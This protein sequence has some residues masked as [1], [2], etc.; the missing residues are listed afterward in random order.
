MLR[1]IC[2]SSVIYHHVHS[3]TLLSW[4][5]EPFRALTWNKTVRHHPAIRDELLYH[6]YFLS[7]TTALFDL[8]LLGVVMG[9]ILNPWFFV[10]AAPFLVCKYRDGGDHLDVAG[11]VVR[12]AAGCVR[13]AIILGVLL[14]SSVR[15]R[16]L[17]I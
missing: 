16:S 6:R 10:L 17:V 3:H 8:L 7:R 15:F 1:P 2:E 9:W 5:A 11:R 12:V 14:S 13:A 4:L